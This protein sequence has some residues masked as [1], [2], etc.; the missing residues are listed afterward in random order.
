[1]V[2]ISPQEGIRGQITSSKPALE[3]RYQIEQAS[4][5]GILSEQLHVT[6]CAFIAQN[7]HRL[8][9][10][11]LANDRESYLQC[12]TTMEGSKKRVVCRKASPSAG[13]TTRRE[14]ME[15]ERVEG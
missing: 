13:Q 9:I 2:V 1:M 15:S 11:S 14:W 7:Q 5:I 8:T 12:I 6:A 4:K 10:L 3:T